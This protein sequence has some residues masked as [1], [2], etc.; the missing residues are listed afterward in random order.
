M[1]ASVDPAESLRIASNGFHLLFAN[2]LVGALGVF[3]DDRYEDSPFHLMGLGVCAFLKAALGMEV[4]LAPVAC[5]RAFDLV[6]G[7]P[8]SW[9]TRHAVSSPRKRAQKST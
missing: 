6:V 9:K 2:D 3:S 7:S 1:A 5:H 4:R 8:S